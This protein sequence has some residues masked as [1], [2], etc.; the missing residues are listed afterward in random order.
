MINNAGDFHDLEQYSYCLS[1]DLF[2]TVVLFT[3]L[4][5]LL[6]PILCFGRRMMMNNAGYF[7]DLKRIRTV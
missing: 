1:F 2:F 7:H 6:I 5:L 4:R 3:K